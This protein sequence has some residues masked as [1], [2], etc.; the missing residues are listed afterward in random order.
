[1]AHYDVN[2]HQREPYVG[3]PRHILQIIEICVKPIF[4]NV[5][6]YSCSIIVLLNALK[7]YSLFIV[8]FVKSYAALQHVCVISFDEHANVACRFSVSIDWLSPRS[9]Y[10]LSILELEKF[11]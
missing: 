8:A 10:S 1:M 9:L 2:M 6:L 7:M 4:Y 5:Y 11:N 3:T